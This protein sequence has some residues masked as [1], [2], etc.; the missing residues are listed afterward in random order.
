MLVSFSVENFKSFLEENLLSLEAK[1]INEY[2]E[3]NTFTQGKYKLL[4][5]AFIFGANASG[6]SNYLDAF[7]KMR[8]SV[9]KSFS[10]AD[11]FLRTIESTFQFNVIGEKNP[12]TFKVEFLIKNTKYFYSFSIKRGLVIHELLSKSIQKEVRIFE[13]YSSDAT[14]TYISTPYKKM[15]KSLS[16]VRADALIISTLSHLNDSLSIEIT[17]WFRDIEF[18]NSDNLSTSGAIYT[19]KINNYI[20]LINLAD[21]R[22]REFRLVDVDVD[23]KIREKLQ[24]IIDL[25]LPSSVPHLRYKAEKYDEEHNFIEDVEVNFEEMSSNGT[26]NFMNMII[27]IMEAIENGKIIII[28]ELESMLHV[29]LVKFVFNLFNSID[30]NKNNSQLITTTHDVFILNE[31]IRRDQVNFVEKNTYGES[32]I[33]SL[34]DF[35]NVSKSDNLLKKY[36]L[37]FYGAIPQLKELV[38]EKKD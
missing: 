3:L 32:S 17:N 18:I 13:R 23:P 5:S 29:S 31:D 24:S 2:E 38:N 37:G 19:D 36:L 34:S 28:D 9:L 22:I 27:P 21:N 11:F 14:Q 8:L 25:E 10:D 15:S 4:K 12:T 20:N 35:R 16:Y 7:Y 33:Y 6:K 30:S 26:K 1:Q